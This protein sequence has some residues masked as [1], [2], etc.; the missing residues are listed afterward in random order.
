MCLWGCVLGGEGW[1][2]SGE[3]TIA[4]PQCVSVASLASVCT[5]GF[6]R[7]W[8]DVTAQLSLKHPQIWSIFLPFPFTMLQWRFLYFRMDNGLFLSHR[9]H[10]PV[11]PS[12][13]THTHT[14]TKPHWQTHAHLLAVMLILMVINDITT[15]C[16]CVVVSGVCV[17]N[18]GMRLFVEQTVGTGSSPGSCEA[19]S[20]GLQ[21]Y[22][23][24][25]FSPKHPPFPRESFSVSPLSL[26]LLKGRVH[27][28][29]TGANVVGHG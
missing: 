18:G 26:L 10:V 11:S 12:L 14:G 22:I 13:H 25:C 19:G 20:Q 23:C 1:I 21:Q 29:L 2:S 27:I 17:C 3:H 4:G 6:V 8:R 9:L 15:A 7:R 24:C 28:F 16:G 5:S